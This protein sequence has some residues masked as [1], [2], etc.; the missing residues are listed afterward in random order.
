[1][2]AHLIGAH[3]IQGIGAGIVPPILDMNMLDEVIE[4]SPETIL[5][6]FTLISDVKL[7]ACA[8]IRSNCCLLSE[9]HQQSQNTF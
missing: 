3:L 4:V 1:M 8:I 2:H 7:C 9:K 6:A 5:F